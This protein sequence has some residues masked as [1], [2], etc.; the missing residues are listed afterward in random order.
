MCPRCP[1]VISR[2]PSGVRGMVFFVFKF[3][4]AN[5]IPSSPPPPQTTIVY[6]RPTANPLLF[7]RL[8]ANIMYIILYIGK[9]IRLTAVEIIIS[10]MMCISALSLY[11]YKHTHTHTQTFRGASVITSQRNGIIILPPPRY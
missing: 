10:R 7:I 5:T 3:S 9:M 8:R 11:L 1:L 4:E 2:R 6:V